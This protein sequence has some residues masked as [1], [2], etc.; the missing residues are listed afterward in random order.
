MTYENTATAE[1]TNQRYLSTATLGCLSLFLA[2]LIPGLAILAIDHALSPYIVASWPT[3]ILLAQLGFL[4]GL[5]LLSGRLLQLWFS[6]DRYVRETFA[7]AAATTVSLVALIDVTGVLGAATP[8]TL[9]QILQGRLSH[10]PSSVPSIAM[11][12]YVL[13]LPISVAIV[14][15]LHN[16][17]GCWHG[18]VSVDQ[19]QREQ[20]HEPG[21]SPTSQHADP[22][23]G[24]FLP[25]LCPPGPR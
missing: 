18:Q 3:P 20:I 24:R 19:H 14:V 15:T 12:D 10:H 23:P 16:R 21:Q 17:H 6:Q 13:L 25:H 8:W 7:F 2:P 11:V 4:F 22:D 9:I 5:L 1:V